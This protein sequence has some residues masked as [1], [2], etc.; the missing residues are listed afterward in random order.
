M[1]GRR[2]QRSVTAAAAGLGAALAA[3]ALLYGED[4]PAW[5]TPLLVAGAL[6]FFELVALAQ[7]TASEAVVERPA[8]SALLVGRLLAAALLA[9]A[10]ATVAQLAAAVPT[11]HGFATGLLGAGA[12]VALFL[13]VAAVARR[14]REAGPTVGPL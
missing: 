10:G 11:R 6:I 9:L 4:V 14:G 8:V 5:S 12:I 13:F 1:S 2:F 7:G 3:L